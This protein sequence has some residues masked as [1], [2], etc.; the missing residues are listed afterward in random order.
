MSLKVAI[1]GSGPAGCYAA[2]KL[3]REAP[4]AE[5]DVLDRM[6]V[7]YGLVRA[8]VAPDH[9]GTKAVSRVFERLFTRSGVGFLGN[10]EVGRDVTLE[11]LRGLYDAVVLATGARIDRRLGIPGEELA[12]VHGSGGF[13]G[14]YN[15]HGERTVPDLSPEL[16][17]V[18]SAVVV[19]NGNVALDVVRVLA[20]TPAELERSDVGTEVEAAVAAA[21]LEEIHV[22]GR[23][24]AGSTSFSVIELQELDALARAEPVVEAADLEGV[25]E[26]ANPAALEVLRGFAGRPGA[27]KPVRIRFHFGAVPAECVGGARVE[28][29]RFARR[30]GGELV[31][32]A[33]LVVTCIGYS[34]A[35]CCSARAEAGV[36]AN[37]D[38]RIG[39]G[40]YVVGWAKRGPSGTIATNRADSHAVAERL[41]REA[42]ASG[43]PGREGLLA[44]LAGRGTRVVDHGGWTRIDA[45]ECARAAPGR[46]RRK[47]T[48]LQEMLA[49][50]G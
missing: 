1:V 29:M 23:R 31:L 41:V 42:A 26:P 19:G 24:D 9:Q 46:V 17:A 39:D 28:R 48:S 4:G 13:V 8:G 2:E 10:V 34:A 40:L 37:V 18:R 16:P 49:A 14:W 3:V 15:C 47:F 45:A 44:L 12:G 50:A 11:E 6:P 7:P 25:G 27:G 22:V 5:I 33:D 20:K 38:G 30:A 43:R 36:F 35:D 32:P 21:P